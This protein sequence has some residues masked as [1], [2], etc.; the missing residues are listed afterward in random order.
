MLNMRDYIVIFEKITIYEFWELISF[1]AVPGYIGIRHFLI[2]TTSWAFDMGETYFTTFPGQTFVNNS[3]KRNIATRQ[4]PLCFATRA[5]RNFNCLTNILRGC[6]WNDLGLPC[7][8]ATEYLRASQ[9][10]GGRLEPYKPGSEWSLS[11]EGGPDKG[12][13]RAFFRKLQAKL[14][15]AILRRRRLALKLTT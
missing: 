13:K 2:A 12:E 11:S 5:D 7:T 9:P 8:R 14:E 4:N 15:V 10:E 1:T 6:L 3:V